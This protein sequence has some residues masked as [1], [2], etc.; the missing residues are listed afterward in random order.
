MMN[1]SILVWVEAALAA[2]AFAALGLSSF[3]AMWVWAV[4]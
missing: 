1:H 4:S 2:V 3:H